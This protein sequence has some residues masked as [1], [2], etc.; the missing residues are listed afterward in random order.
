FLFISIC[1]LVMVAQPQFLTACDAVVLTGVDDSTAVLTTPLSDPEPESIPDPAPATGV[2]PVAAT[3]SINYN[4]TIVTGE[5]VADNLS[6]SAIYRT[7]KFIYG[8]NTSNLLGNLGNLN[9]GDNFTIT[10]NGVV[11]NYRVA[12]K[13]LYEKSA[14]G[15]LNGS[16]SLTY[17]VEVNASGHSVSLMTCAGTSYGNGDAS[18]RLVVFADRA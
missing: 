6:Y 8:H 16:W 10:E 7:G 1:A 15:Y 18:H 11:S 9:I 4:V 17:D 3:M 13:V 2:A 12:D 5:I 14:N